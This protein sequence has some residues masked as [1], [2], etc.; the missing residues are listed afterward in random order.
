MTSG[1]QNPVR[2]FAAA[3]QAAAEVAAEWMQRAGQV[4]AD[5]IRKLNSD[6]AVQEFLETLR[7]T[8]QVVVSREC[9][10]SCADS[11][12]DDIGVCD[13]RAVITRRLPGGVHGKAE[14]ALCAPCAVAQ[15]VAEMP[16]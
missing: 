15:G 3:W 4:T 5:S 8:F 12:P 2:Q 13:R 10:C 16:S 6:P 11:H 9:E 14:I 7:N 1:E